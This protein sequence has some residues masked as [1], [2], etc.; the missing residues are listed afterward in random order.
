MAQIRH[1]DKRIFSFLCSHKHPSSQYAL[2]EQR[3]QLPGQLLLWAPGGEPVEEGELPDVLGEPGPGNQTTIQ[4]GGS[5]WKFRLCWAFVGV[6]QDVIVSGC[7]TKGHH[8]HSSHVWSTVNGQ[9]VLIQWGSWI[10]KCMSEFRVVWG[11]L[12][13]YLNLS[14]VISVQVSD[15]SG[16]KTYKDK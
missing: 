16:G 15:L 11:I 3:R 14:S 2:C 13:F 12:N 9:H 1:K 10:T 5:L 7:R 8:H 4:V 6:I